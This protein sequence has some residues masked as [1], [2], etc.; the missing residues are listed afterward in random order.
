MFLHFL[1][2]DNTRPS[3][4]VLRSHL[5]R[6]DGFEIVTMVNLENCEHSTLG[7]VEELSVASFRI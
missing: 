6:K 3:V 5:L 4:F 7:E 1:L 2:F